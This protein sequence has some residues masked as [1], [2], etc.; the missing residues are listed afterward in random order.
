[1]Y[2]TSNFT[3]YP[4]IKPFSFFLPDS[5]IKCRKFILL[6][7]KII[8]FFYAFLLLLLFS[9][10]YIFG[11]S[12][13]ITSGSN[14]NL[15]FPQ[16]SFSQIL[17]IP[18]PKKGMTVFDNTSNVLRYYNGTEWLIL[19]QNSNT[20]NTTNAYKFANLNSPND[21]SGIS[22]DSQGNSVIVGTFDGNIELNGC[23]LNGLQASFLT[24][25]D[26][27]NSCTWAVKINYTEIKD[28]TVD[29]NDNIYIT[30]SFGGYSSTAFSEFGSTIS[31][32]GGRDIFIAKFN[33]EGVFQW[34]KKSGSIENDIGFSIAVGNEIYI[35][36]YWDGN[37]ISSYHKLLIEKF[38]L[39]GNLLLHRVYT[40]SSG[41]ILGRKI[42]VDK[43]T[44]KYFVGGTYTGATTVEGVTLPSNNTF[45]FFILGFDENNN[46]SWSK[47]GKDVFDDMAMDINQNLYVVGLFHSNFSL[48]NINLTS[49]GPS[50]LFLLKIS[51]F[52]TLEW[53]SQFGKSVN[54]EG[55]DCNDIEVDEQNNLY[56]TGLFNQTLNSGQTTLK[57]KGADDIYVAKLSPSAQ[58][59]WIQKGGS[60]SY[61]SGQKLSV[62]K[63]G[64]I[65]IIGTFKGEFEMNSQKVISS[66]IIFNDIFFIQMSR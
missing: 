6:K 66:E 63:D 31:T 44:G 34:V 46:L 5:R 13:T 20:S 24:K 39:N 3:K 25:I 52:G 54:Y 45:N 36:G 21:A 48:E 41:P 38:D 49:E 10:S 32:S 40:P 35:T 51:K 16:L 57:S 64:R 28:V 4:T 30:G 62:T 61:D 37:A 65:N 22:T 19:S 33:S 43:I 60:S 55:L 14:S 23:T 27:N 1:M 7:S 53:V 18:S 12:T 50:S 9:N 17:N 42:L 26:K 59:I 15:H 2:T 47:Y 29:V 11:Q 8:S 58:L 56:I